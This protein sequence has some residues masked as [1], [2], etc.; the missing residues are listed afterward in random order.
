[1]SLKNILCVA[2]LAA[3]TA[4]P[5]LAQPTLSVDL[6]RNGSGIA[7]LDANGDW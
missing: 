4:S 2:A 3:V 7:Q 6:V 1:M 5:A